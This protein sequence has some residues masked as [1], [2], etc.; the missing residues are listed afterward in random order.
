MT[1]VARTIGIT[2]AV[3]LTAGLLIG[4]LLFAEQNKDEGTCEG[5]V[6]VV[7]DSKDRQYVQAQE[8][9][10]LVQQA[11]LHPKGKPMNTINTGAIEEC[12]RKYDPVHT[13][14]CYKTNRKEVCVEITQRMP[15]LRVVTSTESYFIDTEHHRM[16]VRPTINPDILTVTG[17]VTEKSAAGEIAAFAEW[18]Q[19]D[20]YWRERI[21]Q[22]EVNGPKEIIALQRGINQR[23]VIG[24][25]AQYKSKFKRLRTFMENA[26]ETQ[27][28]PYKELDVRYEGQVIGRK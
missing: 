21:A 9:D 16:A 15:L 6:I 25:T 5:F 3:V 28:P 23:L 8:I 7:K 14:E 17:R 19:E 26:S 13:A 18:L 22:L 24:S 27:M 1:K 12:V 11:G 20:A 4:V 10:R 2:A